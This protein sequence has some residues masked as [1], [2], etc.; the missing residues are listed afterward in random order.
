[1]KNHDQESVSGEAGDPTQFAAELPTIEHCQRLEASLRA[2]LEQ[3]DQD[4]RR[5]HDRIL[6]DGD[7]SSADSALFLR[8]SATVIAS[9]A[10][11]AMALAADRRREPFADSA[12]LAAARDAALW[13]KRRK[14][15][16]EGGF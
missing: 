11:G 7:R 16:K 15:P 3:L 2:R 13:A 12:F 10:A 4:V 9:I 8:G 5:A 6:A 1:M 14:A